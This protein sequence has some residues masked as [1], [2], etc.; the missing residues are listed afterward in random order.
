MIINKVKIGP[1]EP[2]YLIA[3]IGS[4]HNQDKSLA[5]EMIDMAAES[6]ANA[7]K[8]QSIRFDKLYKPTYESKE[9]REWFRQ[10]ELNES[11][12]NDLAEQADKAGIDFLSSPTYVEAIDLLEDCNI[13]AYK[14]A[15]PQVQGNLDIVSRAAQTGKPLIMSL[16]YCEYSDITKAIQTA[17]NQGNNQIAL[18]HCVSKYPM[19]PEEA[20]LKFMKTLEKMTG[21]PIGFSDHS[22]DEHVTIAAAAMGACIVEKHVT[23]DRNLPGPDHHFAMTFTEFKLMKNHLHEISSAMGNGIRHKLSDEEYSHRNSVSR[24]MF[25]KRNIQ[26]GEVINK[27]DIEW[28]RHQGNGVL[29]IEIDSALTQTFRAEGEIN[30][31]EKI[32]WNQL[33]IKSE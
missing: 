5:L 31:G 32:T 30:K 8:F 28:L 4:N 6:G 22:L 13:P 1:G 27:N 14:I 26:S 20:N 33:K 2:I 19:K 23:V 12:Y 17:Q 11:W 9:F 15:S 16:G 3:E 24:V 25:S 7:V 10:I 29:E 21:F 18:L